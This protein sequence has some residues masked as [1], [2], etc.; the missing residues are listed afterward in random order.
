MRRA[1][2]DL[3]EITGGRSEK[4]LTQDRLLQLAVERAI[5]IIGEAARKVSD[6]TREAHPDVAWSGIIAQRHVIAHEY[7]GIQYD[8]IWRIV[9]I[10]APKLGRQLDAILPEPPP[11]PLPEEGVP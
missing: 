2:D 6:E 3:A 5:E 1:I 10:H 9:S 7:G 11:D 4:D 8:K